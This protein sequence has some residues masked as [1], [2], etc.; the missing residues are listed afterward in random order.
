MLDVL[1]EKQLLCKVIRSIPFLKRGEC[2]VIYTNNIIMHVYIFFPKLI[3]SFVY[4]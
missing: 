2:D 3:H 1:P 4:F